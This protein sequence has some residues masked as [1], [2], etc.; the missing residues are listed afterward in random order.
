VASA[1]LI[2]GRHV[3]FTDGPIQ[4]C[5]ATTNAK[6]VA[7][8]AIS[9]LDQALVNRNNQYTDIHGNHQLRRVDL[10]RARDHVLLVAANRGGTLTAGQGAAFA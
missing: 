7:R 1:G 3:Y 5:H 8:C 9:S 10:H 4:L 6:G 2:R